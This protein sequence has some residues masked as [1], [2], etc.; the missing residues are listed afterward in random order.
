NTT[1]DDNPNRGPGPGTTVDDHDPNVTEPTTPHDDEPGTTATTTP[2]SP[3]TTDANNSGKGKGGGGGGGGGS[4]G[5]GGTR[6]GRRPPAHDGVVR[7]RPVSAG[8]S[9]GQVFTGPEGRLRAIGDA[10]PLE[11][12]GEVRFHRALADPE[13]SGDLLVGHPAA[14]QHQHLALAVGERV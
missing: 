8:R 10:K 2:G 5:G 9:S 14:Y 4:G 3:T 7:A 11:H 6:G 1:V 12:V 13:L